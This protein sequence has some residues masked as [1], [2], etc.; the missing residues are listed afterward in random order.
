MKTS[1][2]VICLMA[3]GLTGGILAAGGTQAVRTPEES[4]LFAKYVDPSSGVT[5][6]MLNPGMIDENQQS[7][8]FTSKSMT[9]DGRF[10]VLDVSQ[11]EFRTDR[12]RRYGGKRKA[13]VD[14][15]TDTWTRLD[16]LDGAIPFLDVATDSLYYVRK[17]GKPA[18]CRRDL[19]VDPLK[20]I[21]IVP[22]PYEL[23]KGRSVAYYCTHL[24]L[25][26]DR[27]RAFLES[28]LGKDKD[29]AYVQG[30]VNLETG[31][32]EPWGT[33][34]FFC[35]H[36]QINPSRDDIA[37]CAWECCWE[38]PGKA[39][40]KKTGWY[41]RMWLVYPDGRRELVPARER[42]SAS[43]EVWD[44]DG[45]GFSWCG[46][47][48]YHHDLAT[49]KQECWCPIKGA[50][51]NT[52]S[53][54][55]R[56]VTYDEAPGRWWRGCPWRVGFWNRET[57]KNVWVYDTRPALCPEK[58]QSRLH[59]DPHPHF[60]CKGRYVVSTINSADGH[61]DLLVTPVAPLVEMTR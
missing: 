13:V 38:E 31:A 21:E 28:K 52:L 56:Y 5:S 1:N 27:K 41:P 17:G 54:D 4:K 34:D 51:H 12:K 10:L 33:T 61:M 23:A 20:E 7:I 22:I 11:N 2:C 29:A 43:H 40:R 60:V 32:Y 49:G 16:E 37:L 58:N 36:G 59:P 26:K 47:G 42:N 18:I 48:V 9:D 24:T 39:Y 14:L 45:S 55:K 15:A 8:Y 30:C 6:W 25:T 46:G 50:R 3:L 57:K 35:N 44:D 19:L 53:P